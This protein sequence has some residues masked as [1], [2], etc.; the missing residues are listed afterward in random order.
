MNP[1][2]LPALRSACILLLLASCASTAHAAYLA[3][4]TPVP[5]SGGYQ[6]P[7]ALVTGSG[8][9]IASLQYT[10]AWPETVQLEHVAPGP[11]AAAAGKDLVYSLRGRSATVI[12]AGF[13]Q[14]LI[15]GGVIAVAT[16]SVKE[17]AAPQIQ[18]ANIVFSDPRGGAVAQVPPP[19]TTPPDNDQQPPPQEDKDTPE[20]APTPPADN[21][22]TS[23]GS[24]R[25]LIGDGA[26]AYLSPA[27]SRADNRKTAEVPPS[28]NATQGVPAD[29]RA[30]GTPIADSTT[31]ITDA[32]AGNVPWGS[33][34]RR[35]ASAGAVA[36]APRNA[37]SDS[38]ARRDDN[39]ATADAADPPLRMASATARTTATP[40]DAKHAAMPQAL[41]SLPPQTYTTG[42][43]LILIAMLATLL[44]LAMAAAWR[45]LR[46]R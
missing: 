27:S 8:E 18:I 33:D 16:L 31:Q 29:Q 14:T 20:P 37:F 39:R 7:I 1:F 10:L 32:R 38:T 40:A 23:P 5:V 24:G 19:A 17:G 45:C 44:L 41:R 21:G 42:Q 28:R 12:V 26:A 4:G 3:S 2:S 46:R 11:A 13:N 36:T 25:S 43:R 6:I 35:G 22:D 15:G 34:P 9:T 30:N